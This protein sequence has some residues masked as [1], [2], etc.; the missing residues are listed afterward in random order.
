MIG[1]LL[2]ILAKNEEQL[3]IKNNELENH[4]K[5]IKLNKMPFQ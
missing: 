2:N 3:I 5:K 1:L 4:I